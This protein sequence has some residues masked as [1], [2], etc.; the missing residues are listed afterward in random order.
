MATDRDNSTDVVLGRGKDRMGEVQGEG[1]VSAG[2]GLNRRTR[3]CQTVGGEGEGSRDMCILLP[4]LLEFERRSPPSLR[5]VRERR[6]RWGR[7]TNKR[8]GG[9]TDI[10]WRDGR[11]T[12]GC[13]QT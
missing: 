12:S 8:R 10:R 5:S 9:W 1:G 4:R 11:G 2:V 7:R 13:E 3:D 6:K